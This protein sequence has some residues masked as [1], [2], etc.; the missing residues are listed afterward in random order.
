MMHNIEPDAL[1]I[2]V[3]IDMYL[4]RAYIILHTYYLYLYMEEYICL[5]IVVILEIKIKCENVV[6]VCMAKS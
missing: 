6:S 4:H 1:Y 2:I 5:N 3:Y